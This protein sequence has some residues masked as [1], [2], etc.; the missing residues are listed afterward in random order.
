MSDHSAD[1]DPAL[2]TKLQNKQE[3]LAKGDQIHDPQYA[4][5]RP[6]SEAP[7]ALEQ[8][9]QRLK[10]GE[11]NSGSNDAKLESTS[12]PSIML[13]NAPRRRPQIGPQ[14]QADIPELQQPAPSRLSQ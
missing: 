3:K 11:A 9:D 4:P 12:S 2:P 1:L 8:A 14:H 6:S 13:N 7:Q 10:E 5:H